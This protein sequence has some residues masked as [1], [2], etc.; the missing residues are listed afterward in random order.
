MHPEYVFTYFHP[1]VSQMNGKRVPQSSKHGLF[2]PLHEKDSLRPMKKMNNSSWKRAVGRIGLSCGV[3]ALKHTFGH[4]LRA[5]GV[6]NKTRKPLLG[7]KNDDI[8]T[9]YSS[10][11][12]RELQEA[13]EKVCEQQDG[14]TPTLTIL[15]R[16]TSNRH[17]VRSDYNLT[18]PKPSEI[19]T[20]IHP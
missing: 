20:G 17:V 2:C 9:H 16:R 1:G 8:T 19:K 3:H 14:A 13:A 5:A 7:H 11:E 15:K 6:N 10:V 12:L 4:R 18:T